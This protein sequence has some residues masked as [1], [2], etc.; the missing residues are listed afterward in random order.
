MCQISNW[1]YKY[2]GQKEFR[3]GMKMW[4]SLA[5]TSYVSKAVGVKELMSERTVGWEKGPAPVAEELHP[6]E[7]S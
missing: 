3:A 4:E 6:V 5:H 7:D 1:I 2:E